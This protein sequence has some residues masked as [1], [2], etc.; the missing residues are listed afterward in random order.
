MATRSPVRAGPVP[1]ALRAVMFPAYRSPSGVRLAQLAPS[2]EQ[3][4]AGELRGAI[5]AL[6]DIVDRWGEVRLRIDT[7]VR[8]RDE[9]ATQDAADL[10]EATL[11]GEPGV[12]PGQAR[13]A[14]ADAEL[15]R[16]AARLRSVEP[17]VNAAEAAYH[18]AL[19]SGREEA[20]AH[21]DAQVAKRDGRLRKALDA[22]VGELDEISGW[23]RVGR[24]VGRPESGAAALAEDLRRLIDRID[25][26]HPLDAPLVMSTGRG[27]LRENAQIG[28]ARSAQ[29]RGQ[30]A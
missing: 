2:P 14:R 16:D 12:G 13:L 3:L 15:V 18:A 5:I 20:I 4:P 1:D 23:D 29:R 28:D 27:D 10:A 21:V 11:A 9:A 24:A 22:A 25:N 8:A 6:R 7:G 26:P 30:P 17:A 19:A